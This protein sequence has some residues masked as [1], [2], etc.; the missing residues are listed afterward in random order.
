MASLTGPGTGLR[1]T[2]LFCG[3][4]GDTR[5]FHEAGYEPFLAANHSARNIETHA[6]NFPDTEH[7]CADINHYD[8]RNLPKTE[9]LWASPVC[10]EISPAGGRRR[11]KT[12]RGQLDLLE[13]HGHVSSETW[14]RTRATAYDV[15]RATE[16]HGYLAVLCENVLEF[17]TDWPL[18]WWW[19]EGFERLGYN[20]Q[21][22]C[23]SSAHIGDDDN[24]HAPQWR[25][26]VYIAFTRKGIPLPDLD[27]RPR[28]LCVECGED[29]A[30]RQWWKDPRKPKLGK[31]RSQYLYRC[32][33]TKCR[34]AIVEPYVRP[35]AAAI[36]WSDLGQ[37]IGDRRRPLAVSTMRRIRAGLEMFAQPAVVA[38][39]GNTY[40][41]PGSGYVRAWPAYD[42]PLPVRTCTAGDGIAVPPFMVNANHD[43][44][45]M[46]PAMDR[47]L[48]AR[49]T[50]IGDGIAVPGSFIT[51][52]RN[53]CTARDIGEPL[54]TV[55]AEGNHLYLTVPD[56][57]FYIKNYT[58]RANPAQMSKDV[59][60]E[61]LGAVTTGR[62]HAL[63]IPYYRTGKAKST[64]DPLSTVTVKDRFALLTSAV[65]VED[66][67]YRMLQ[68]R[69]QSRAQRFGDDYVLTGNKGEQTAGAGNAV[70]VNVARWIGE[71]V[72]KVLGGGA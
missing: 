5:G 39:A 72:A 29:V 50:K 61:P 70:S 15:L 37:R 18:F 26:R 48:P 28:A 66:C 20:Y 59:R 60:S 69:E 46:Y 52:L 14:E 43:D 11:R 16:V 30:A 49:T 67:H 68:P 62:N 54:N 23:V 57:A 56:G 71:Q 64:D 40:E 6:A 12:A 25:D 13:E 7:L 19:L 3:I 41:R 36:D 47:P 27:P 21:I 51:V 45:R 55:A 53:N 44:D 22:V 10:T 58:P 38:V 17:A 2:H 31:Y 1:S 35:A 65:E 42:A 33:N 63:V 24:E 34:H 4:G 32:P 8:M 9:V